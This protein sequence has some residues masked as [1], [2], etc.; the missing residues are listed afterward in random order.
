MK[1][2]M[3]DGK[4]LTQVEPRFVGKMKNGICIWLYG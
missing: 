2:K 1:M 4:L 3:E